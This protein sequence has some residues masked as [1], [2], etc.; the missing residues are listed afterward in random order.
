MRSARAAVLAWSITGLI[1]AVVATTAVLAFLNR[2]SLRNIDEASLTEIV[3]PIG[4]AFVGGLV[5]SRLPSNPLGWVFLAISLTTA[6]PGASEQYTRFAFMTEP[7]APF[8]AWIPWFGNM[9]DTLVYP[10][11]LATLALLLIPNGRLLSARWRIVAWTGAAVTVG[12]LVTTMLDPNLIRG[13]GPL[14]VTNPTG[15][16]GMT[17]ISQGPVGYGLFLG[18]L[19]V[20]ALAGASV[21]IRLRRSKGD[22]RLQL[23]WVAYAV[24]FSVLVNVGATLVS[25]FLLPHEDVT[26]AW[27]A[28]ATIIGFGVALPASF[29][30]AI[31]RYRLYDLDL[32]LNRTV[33]YGAVTLVLA[34]AFGIAD[35]LAQRA[36]ESVFNQPSDLVSAGL[37]VGAALAFG[38]MRR[39]IRPVVDRFLPARARLTLLFT[40]IVGSS[41]A[42]VDLGDERWRS[43]LD[44]Y[45]V[46]VRGELS[47]YRGREVNTAGDAFFAVFD[48]P[49]AA[50]RCAEGIRD[51][52]RGLGLRVRTGLHVGDVEMRGEQV[53]GLAVHAAAR[54]MSEA[55]D[56]QILISSDLA[57][58]LSGDVPLQDAGRHALKGVPGEWQLY[59]VQ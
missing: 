29:G 22:E 34:A 37:G 2:A 41:L 45:R 57:D 27:L 8:S 46:A 3:L 19:G 59:A 1:L 15:V 39:W 35:V 55:G 21:I 50:V 17:A 30:V 12:F 28:I 48:R 56:D 53:S 5:A 40:D 7:G 16:Q 49:A 47:R 18:G 26:P 38:P 43:V 10:A 32:L 24:A 58:V 33:V 25:I 51:A 4:F 23:R 44:R 42:I 36:V 13:E 9:V 6:I 14:R 54:V 20:L 11:G 31:L 52:V